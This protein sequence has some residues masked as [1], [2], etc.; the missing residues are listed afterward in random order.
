MHIETITQ[1]EQF[2]NLK[3]QWNSL[4]NESPANSV[5][6]TWE[7]LFTW[8]EVYG[9][10]KRTLNII[11][12]K[13]DNGRLIAI[14]P[15]IVTVKQFGPLLKRRVLE[16]LGSGEHEKDEVC[17]NY[18]DF[19]VANDADN[20]YPKLKEELLKGINDGRWDEFFLTSVP[21]ESKSNVNLH[22]T[23]SSQLNASD[24]NN[25][26]TPCAIIAL[27]ET[28]ELYLS[29]LNK[30]WRHQIKKGR[31]ELIAKGNVECLDIT[32]PNEIQKAFDDLIH[33]HQNRWVEAGQPGAFSSTKFN[34][35]HKK[36]LERFSINHW[37]GIH[38]L[39]LNGHV[40][41]ATHRFKYQQTVY[42]YQTGYDTTIP[43]KVGFGLL[44]RSFDIEESIRQGYRFY[45]FY[46]AKA[47]SYKWHFAKDKRE[48]RD[49][50]ITKKDAIYH[51]ERGK[52][53]LRGL[54]RTIQ[55]IFKKDSSPLKV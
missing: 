11:S 53:T 32:D 24:Q 16:F 38:L 29:T 25:T 46:K 52:N 21:V 10:S 42:S 40:L 22:I 33:L 9:D 54:K 45:D 5:Y 41:A 48:V 12:L 30:H 49:I 18:L 2:K 47:G 39:K 36:T 35:F 17:S 27:P 37:V 15:L 1:T 43:T 13:D 55:M 28:W 14:A 8:W 51:F 31:A 7:W 19:I 44:E 20:V 26:T 6:L 34:N 50:R 4:L 3:D 23:S